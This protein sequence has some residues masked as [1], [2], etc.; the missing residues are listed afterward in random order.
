MRSSALISLVLSFILVANTSV[1]HSMETDQYNLPPEPLFDIGNEV[2]DHIAENLFTAVARIN[3]EIDIHQACLGDPKQKG[4][5]CGTPQE[6]R[7]RLEYLRSND[8]VA[9]E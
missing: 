7:S 8:A 9:Y 4:N 1:V 2:S 5:K 3:G 6:E